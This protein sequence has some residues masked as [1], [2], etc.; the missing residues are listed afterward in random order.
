MII[1]A[2]IGGVLSIK[3]WI[4]PNGIEWAW[5]LSLGVFGYFA[6]LYMT[7]ALQGG[8]LSQVAPLKYIEVIFTMAIGMIWFNETYTLIGLVGITLIISGLTLNILFRKNTHYISILI[9]N[10]C[11]SYLVENINYITRINIFFENQ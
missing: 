7:K 3:N 2:I 5:L 10:G 11:L 8:I 1:S 6:Q 9:Q 4:E